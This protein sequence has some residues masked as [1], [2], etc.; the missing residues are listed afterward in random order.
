[1]RNGIAC[2]LKNVSS[3]SIIENFIANQN[4]YGLERLFQYLSLSE[5]RVEQRWL[6]IYLKMEQG[7]F[8]KENHQEKKTLKI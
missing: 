6:G 2:F 4:A 8:E 5:Q 3:D 7:A 1:M